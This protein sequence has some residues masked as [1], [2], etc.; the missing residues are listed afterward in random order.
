M[1]IFYKPI[2]KARAKSLRKNSTPAEIILWKRL[3]RK[4]FYGYQF[5][6]QKPIAE[7]IVDFYCSKLKLIIEIDGI[8]HNYKANYDKSRQEYLESIGLSVLRFDEI[9]VRKNIEGVFHVLEEY[10]NRNNFLL[11]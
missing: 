6:R 4:Q 10:L 5:M 8:S 9:Y 11:P 2:L 3:S 1:K 7:Y